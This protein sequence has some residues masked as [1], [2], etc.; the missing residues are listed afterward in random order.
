MATGSDGLR[1]EAR[2]KLCGHAT[3]ATAYV[4]FRYY[5]DK[6]GLTF[7]STSGDLFV[8]KDDGYIAMDFP[9]IRGQETKVTDLMADA[10]GSAPSRAFID[11]RLLLVYEDE[12][13]L[14]S[15]LTKNSLAIAPLH[16]R[17]VAIISSLPGRFM[18]K[19]RP[20]RSRLFR[21]LTKPA[22]AKSALKDEKSETIFASVVRCTCSLRSQVSSLG[23]KF[24]SSA[25]R[26]SQGLAVC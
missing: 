15:D 11:D 6:D 1:R 20:R 5:E 2:V 16:L 4:I 3:L 24:V 17:G 23:C 26:F 19:V 12:Q 22:N 21:A 18:Q 14:Q 9:A 10:F 7:H 13:I 8:G 25:C